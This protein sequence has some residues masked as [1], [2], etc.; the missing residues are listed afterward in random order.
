MRTEYKAGI[1]QVTVLTNKTPAL[2]TRVTANNVT[3]TIG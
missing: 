1:I 3:C 2:N